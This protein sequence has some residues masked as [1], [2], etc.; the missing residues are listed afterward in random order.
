MKD[1]STEEKSSQ[2]KR[3]QCVLDFILRIENKVLPPKTTTL[4]IICGYVR[5]L[6]NKNVGLD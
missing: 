5:M 3:M 1:N 4:K 6:R 2:G